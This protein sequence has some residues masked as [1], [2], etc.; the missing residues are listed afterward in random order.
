MPTGLV[1]TQPSPV[2][3]RKAAQRGALALWFERV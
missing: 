1:I 2:R 3:C